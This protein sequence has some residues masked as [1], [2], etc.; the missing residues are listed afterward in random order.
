M[1]IRFGPLAD[2]LAF[3]HT[4]HLDTGDVSIPAAMASRGESVTAS[5]A[6]P[7]EADQAAAAPDSSRPGLELDARWARARCAKIFRMTARSWSAAIRRSRPHNGHRQERHH[8]E[9]PAADEPSRVASRRFRLHHPQGRSEAEDPGG[10]SPEGLREEKGEHARVVAG[11]ACGPGSRGRLP[12]SC[13]ATTWS[14]P[15]PDVEA[16]V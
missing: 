12:G 7:R 15:A 13:S 10:R 16:P 3:S 6:R 9:A 8:E 5:A 11:G 1:G 2:F 4:F 14:T